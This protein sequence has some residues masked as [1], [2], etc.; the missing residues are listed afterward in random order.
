MKRARSFGVR[1]MNAEERA[2]VNPYL[3]HKVPMGGCSNSGAHDEFVGKDEALRTFMLSVYNY[4][5]LGLLVTALAAFATYA[6]TVTG[7]PN[8][9]ALDEVGNAYLITQTEYLTELG[10]ILWFTPL[11]YAVC[12]GPLLVLLFASAAFR[13]LAPGPTFVCYM[14]VAVLIGISFSSLA[15]TYTNGSITR[16]FFIT[17]ASFGAL[18]LFGYTTKKDLSGWGS[19]LWMG[20]FG[21]IISAIVNIFWQSDVLQFAVCSI[22]VIVFAGFTAY[23][24]QMIRDAYSDKM[25]ANTTKGLAINGALDLYLDFVNLFR[26]LM[27]FLGTSED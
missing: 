27:F 8:L 2:A 9:A 15:L 19:F 11:S 12:F 26:F 13:D 25:D 17:A 18:S 10:A 23:D 6:V 24:T 21:L 16:V 20:L 1:G 14:I 7:D 22:G 4:M 3:G 5:M